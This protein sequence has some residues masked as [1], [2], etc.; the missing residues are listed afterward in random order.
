MIDGR[1]ISVRM[2]DELAEQI[3]AMA[4]AE[5][6]SV[7]EAMRAAAYRYIATRRSDHD[8]QERLRKRLEEDREVLEALAESSKP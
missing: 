2:P 8:F 3:D 7:S 6:V 5:G 4:R 1:V